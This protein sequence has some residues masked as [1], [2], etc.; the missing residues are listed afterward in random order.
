MADLERRLGERKEAG[1]REG[2]VRGN[3]LGAPFAPHGSVSLET[4]RFPDAPNRPELGACRLDPGDDYVGVT[5]L[6]FGTGEP[7]AL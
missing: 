2:G 5:E 1:L 3:S 6:R 7:P 4:Q